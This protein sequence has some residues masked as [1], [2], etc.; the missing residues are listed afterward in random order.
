MAPHS[1]SEN[2]PFRKL[3]NR[4]RTRGHRPGSEPHTYEEIANRCGVS[5]QFLHALMTGRQGPGVTVS[6]VRQL[7]EG[8]GVGVALVIDCL[9]K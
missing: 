4:V 9:E 3:V 5:R 7:A 6:S 1:H 8:L 2:H